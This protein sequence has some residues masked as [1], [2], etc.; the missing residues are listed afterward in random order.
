MNILRIQNMLWYFQKSEKI[1][2]QF[3]LNKNFSQDE[4]DFAL[5]QDYILV[6]EDTSNTFM[7]DVKYKITP[8]GIKIRDKH[9]N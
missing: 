8:L 5:S 6:C 1:E 7:G 9:N 3:L 4:I 2:N